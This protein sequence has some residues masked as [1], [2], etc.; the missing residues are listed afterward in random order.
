M[1]ARYD[2]LGLGCVAIDDLLYVINHW[3]ACPTPPTACPADIAPA[4]CNHDGV[5][6]IDDLLLVIN[7]WGNTCVPLDDP[8]DPG[9]LRSVEDCM[10][11]ASEYYEANTE[12]WNNFV[13]RCVAALCANHTINCD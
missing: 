1:T 5:V 10:D 11:A 12:E 9:S 8:Y 6:N 3:G 4:P 13:N 7:Q 2:V